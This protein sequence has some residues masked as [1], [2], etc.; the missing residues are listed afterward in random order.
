MRKRFTSGVR[1]G[2][3]ILYR[4][5]RDGANLEEPCKDEIFLTGE[6]GVCELPIN[7]R[8]AVIFNYINEQRGQ[9]SSK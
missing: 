6:R 1:R 2:G 9:T 5:H 8:W 3:P 7:D 4:Y